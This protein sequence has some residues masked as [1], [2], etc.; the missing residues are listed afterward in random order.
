MEPP[1]HVGAL[2]VLVLFGKIDGQLIVVVAQGGIGAPIQQQRHH[3]RVGVGP[4]RPVQG[5]LASLHI[6]RP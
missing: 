4:R 3:R 6:Q 5:R 1:V 2:E